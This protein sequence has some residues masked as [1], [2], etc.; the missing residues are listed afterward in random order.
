MAKNPKT[1]GYLHGFTPQEQERLY[2]QARFVEHRVHDRLPFRRSKRLIEV[3]SGVGAQT[4][5]LLRHFPDLHIT[6]VDRSETNLEQ[7][8]NH[9]GRLPWADGR[10]EL[11]RA[12]ASR[13]EFPADSFDS[14]FLCWILEHVADPLLVLS[15]TRRVLRPGS[16][17]VCTEVQNASFFVDPYSPQTLSYWMAFNDY[18]IELGGDPFV[19]AKLGNLLQAVGYRD[20]QTE[21]KTIHLD[22]RL[23]GERAEFL[24]YWS[25]L[26]L[27]G[28]PGLQE[29]G[30]VS[31]ELVEGMKEEL[32]LVA[33]NPNAVFFY[34]FIQARA[35]VL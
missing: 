3:G 21:V 34:C 10:Y 23:P 16:P 7:A 17:I 5:I 28:A 15:E 9:L 26:L 35:V 11:V 22:N 12:D 14:A 20:I 19:G 1:A 25:E 29:A 4:E 30:K 18:Q 32:R 24:A 2:R 6:G 27:S 13:L 8:R 31:A 33:H